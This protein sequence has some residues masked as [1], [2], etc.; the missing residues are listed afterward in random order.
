MPSHYATVAR[1]IERLSAPHG[2]DDLDALAADAGMSPG[3]FQR[4]FT[5]WAGVS[6]KRFA[7]QL[8][9]AR[10]RAALA[11]GASVLEA[12]MRAGLSSP[13]RLHDLAVTYDA[14]TPGELRRGAEGV[15]L[16]YGWAASPFGDALALV[17][18]RGLCGLSF[19]DGDRDATLA[20]ATA[21]WPR[22]GLTR[23]DA[24]VAALCGEAVLDVRVAGRCGC[25]SGAAARG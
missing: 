5:E 24:S 15:D 6:P 12:T 22:A 1:A 23:D 8:S 2:A 18:P 7:Q 20:D 9:L 21:R 3:H 19:C 11:E 16:R 25:T 14:L 4:V 13:G 10:A 17:S